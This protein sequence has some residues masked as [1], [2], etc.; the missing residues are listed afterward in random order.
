MFLYLN[1]NSGIPIYR[2]MLQQLRQRIVSDQLVPNEKLPSARE[3]SRELKVNFL[4]VAKVYQC[5]E[6]EGFVEFR[7][8]LGTFVSNNPRSHSLAEKRKL[9]APA[10]QQLVTEANHLQL[11]EAEIQNLVHEQFKKIAS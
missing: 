10:L 4:T 1:P 3:L 2:Q 8:G 11:E 6:R 9:L 5:L 7:R